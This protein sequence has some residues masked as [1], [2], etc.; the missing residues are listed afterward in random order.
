MKRIKSIS[1]IGSFCNFHETS[2]EFSLDKINIFFGHNGNGKTTLSLILESLNKVEPNLILQKKRFNCNEEPECIIEIDEENYVFKEGCWKN[3]G[4]LLT[5]PLSKF[6]V[7]NESYVKNNFFADKFTHSHKVNMHKIIF[8]ETGIEINDKLSKIKKEID[9]LK[10]KIGKGNMDLIKKIYN[11]P[12]NKDVEYIETQTKLE[13]KINHVRQKQKIVSQR[14]VKEI[15]EIN[16]NLEELLPILNTNINSA[17]HLEAKSKMLEYSKKYFKVD[18]EYKEF[19][20]LGF[21]NMVDSICPFC[22]QNITIDEILNTY[23]GYFDT[24]FEEIKNKLDLEIKKA[25]NLN[26]DLILNGI[27]TTNTL[28]LT[29]GEFWLQ[30]IG[31]FLPHNFDFSKIIES[32]KELDS[33]LKNKLKNLD[34]EFNETLLKN[35][36][37]EINQIDMLIRE[38]NKK[39]KSY[40]SKIDE[41]KQELGK[42]EIKELIDEKEQIDFIVDR[43]TIKKEFFNEIITKKEEEEKLKK[44]LDEYNTTSAKNYIDSI[45]SN[46]E[47]LGITE[48]K[49]KEVESF[50]H[51]SA[52]EVGTEIVLEINNCPIYMKSDSIEAPAFNN[53]LSEGEKN[54]LSFAFFI[55]ELEKRNDLTEKIIVFD[56][57]LTSLDDNRKVLTAKVI[58]SLETKVSQLIVLTHKDSFLS[59]LNK[60]VPDA[61]FFELKK[62]STNG[63][64][65]ILLDMKERL[66]L[67]HMKIIEN[68]DLF[69]RQEFEYPNLPNDIR[70]AF[71]TL[72]ED[73]YHL[74]L[75]NILGTIVT[76]RTF[77][78]LFWDNNK[79]L[80]EKENLELVCD[81]AN[82]GSHSGDEISTYSDMTYA[83][84]KAFVIKALELMEKI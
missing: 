15:P 65:I 5:S 4:N 64:K 24:E 8:G 31:E 78:S 46:L 68:L 37:Y 36:Q 28:N 44:E 77:Q 17:S 52:N 6:I 60:Q 80:D 84:K 73:K 23:R 38:E 35:F 45:N 79:L 48:I 10:I 54:A 63:S 25:I 69:T 74:K 27:E 59:K 9:E 43:F 33:E 53:T 3:R 19:I 34:Y 47:K 75:K 62:D 40:N 1:N 22:Q 7:F 70:K 26:L 29:I 83:E 49:I 21:K 20:S 67:P 39:I 12:E 82:E 50:K 18:S 2:D 72:I 55:A 30:K 76:R 71:E 16:I 58:K 57:P 66:K 51:S 81:V 56:D 32:K 41:F 11:I 42:I 13:E 61:K 14:G